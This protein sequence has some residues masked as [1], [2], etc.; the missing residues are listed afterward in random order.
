MYVRFRRKS[1][2]VTYR[3]RSNNVLVTPDDVST[4][5]PS[6]LTD[7]LNGSSLS[8]AYHHVTLGAVSFLGCKMF[9]HRII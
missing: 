2:R 6:D 4:L 8:Q 9:L 3:L 7:V 1:T 5:T